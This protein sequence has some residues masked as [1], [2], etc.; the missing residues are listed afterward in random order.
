[1]TCCLKAAF[2]YNR[3]MASDFIIMNLVNLL[4]IIQFLDMDN[5]V[6]YTT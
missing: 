2:D 5:L 3:P 4:N 1:V 6:L